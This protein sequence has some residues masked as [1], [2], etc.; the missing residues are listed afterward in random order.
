MKSK[1]LALVVMTC[2]VLMIGLT[3]VQCGGKSEE[4]L[5][6]EAVDQIGD[7]AENRNS[8]GVLSYLTENFTDHHDRPKEEIEELLE[9]YFNRYGGIVVNLLSTEII[10]ISLPNAEVETEVALSSGAAKV[11]R[12]A[13]RYAGE[14]YHFKLSLVKEGETWRCRS[15]SWENLTLQELFPESIK[16]MEEL[17]PGIL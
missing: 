3:L 14:F 6:R 7:Y 2:L 13:V 15:A 12:K 1:T 5:I 9:K 17:F 11:F 4:D 10:S 16:M 8:S